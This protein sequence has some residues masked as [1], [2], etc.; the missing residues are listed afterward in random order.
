[1]SYRKAHRLI[2]LNRQRSLER[3]LHRRVERRKRIKKF[4]YIERLINRRKNKSKKQIQE[5]VV[6]HKL[7]APTDFRLTKNPK[8]SADFFKKMLKMKKERSYGYTEVRIDLSKVDYIDF[9]SALMLNAVGEE[10]SVCNCLVKGNTSLNPDVHRYLKES[11]FFNKKYTKEGKLIIAP[12]N[13]QIMEFTTGEGR[14]KNEYVYKFVDILKRVYA[15]LAESNTSNQDT[16]VSIFKEICGNAIEWGDT[17]RR[18][19]TIGVKF[20]KD[21]AIFVALDLGQGILKSLDRRLKLRLTD[22][23]KNKN[24]AQ[25]LE[26]VFDNYYGSKT[27]EPNRNQG[28]PF[29]KYCNTHSKIKHLCVITNNVILKFNEEGTNVFSKRNNG[30]I[31]TLYTWEID[32]ES[33]NKHDGHDIHGSI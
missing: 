24:D 22:K 31:G 7:K 19:W 12:G 4:L 26:G 27:K 5:V 29:I 9:P 16:Y 13:S 15:H 17:K 10:L 8:Q 6:P 30:I 18:N 21:K 1:M 32:K 23:F 25:I 28:L 11:G 3:S 20:E 2:L 33:I 14:W